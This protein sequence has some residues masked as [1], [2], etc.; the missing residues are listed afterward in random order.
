MTQ[1][2][3]LGLNQTPVGDDGLEHLEGLTQLKSLY[4]DGTTVGDAGLQHLKGLAK[5]KILN[6][7]QTKVSAAAAERSSQGVAERKYIAMKPA[8]S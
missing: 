1:L 2:R 3:L 4:L 5:L 8:V 7:G 6:L